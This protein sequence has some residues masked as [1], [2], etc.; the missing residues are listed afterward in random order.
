M[1]SNNVFRFAATG[2]MV[3]GVLGG[4]PG[5]SDAVQGS[6]S[7]PISTGAGV[8]ASDCLYILRAAVGSV[9]PTK[10][11]VT[12]PKGTA[13]TR[14]SDALLC[15]AY[16]VGQDLTLDCP[17]G[18]PDVQSTDF[19][20]DPTDAT[21]GDPNVAAKFVKTDYVGAFPQDLDAAGADWTQD[22][23]VDLHGNPQVWEPATGGTLNGATPSADGNCPAGTTDIGDKAMPAPFTGSMDEC[24]LPGRFAVDG[25]TLTLTNDNVYVSNTS[26][27]IFFVGDGDGPMKDASN[28]VNSTLVIEPGTLLLG[29][30]QKIIAITRGS[31][32]I[33]NGT[34]TD[35][36]VMTSEQAFDSWVGGNPNDNAP[37]QWGGFI[38]TGFGVSNKCND[39]TYCDN[40]VE[41]TTSLVRFGGT[42]TDWNCGSI[43]YLV[44][45]NT[46]FDLGGG[47]DTNALTVYSCDYPTTI[48]HVQSDRAADDAFEF[49]GGSA[50]ADH[51]VSTNC[52]DDNIDTDFG[53]DG[54]VQFVVV[55]QGADGDKGFEWDN[56]GSSDPSAHLNLPRSRPTAANVTLLMNPATVQSGGAMSFRSQ[57]DANIWNLI[58]TNGKGYGMRSE[59][60]SG[61]T[62]VATAS[63]RGVNGT[64]TLNFNNVW[65]YHP[66]LATDAGTSNAKLRGQADGGVNVGDPA[67]LLATFNANPNNVLNAD[68]GLDGAGYPNQ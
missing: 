56:G 26:D 15:L 53:F 11:C 29:G 36:V 22:W 44:I 30:A 5:T 1:L 31:Q 3:A 61:T 57:T 58:A 65:M 46:G 13:P 63:A 42:E 20:F 51:L 6:C 12:Q 45:Q 9:T 60:Y 43:N 68:P 66:H 4:T 27:D 34:E 21:I 64:D 37:L 19:T 54:G 67:N 25:G 41:G 33:V 59:T 47:N 16:S 50:V 35:P 28:T 40:I 48:S 39:P 7:Q 62:I 17:C 18:T 49:F 8:V 32:A 52:N 38:L 10:A 2:L 55:K 24:E 23:T 14:A